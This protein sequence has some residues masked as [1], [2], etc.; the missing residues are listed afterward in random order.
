MRL[1][2][3]RCILKLDIWFISRCIDNKV[4]P[5]FC[6]VKTPG[7][8]PINLKN[9]FQLKIL[10]KEICNHYSKINYINCKLKVIYDSLLDTIG[11]D[12]LSSFLNDVQ[13]KLDNV[14]SIK[15][16]RLKSKLN[17]LIRNKVILH[18]NNSN[19][20]FSNFVFH[21]R[22]KNLSSVVFNKKEIDLLNLG[23]KYSIP[24]KVSVKDLQS[25]SIEL[26]IIIQNLSVPLNQKTSIRNSCFNTINKFKNK[27]N[28]SSSS[29]NLS[30]S[31]CIEEVGGDCQ[32]S[33]LNSNVEYWVWFSFDELIVM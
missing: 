21:P 4:F 9:T 29:I 8:V 24:K 10:K 7:N 3:K 1:A 15:F 22:L 19:T 31:Q 6:K 30:N 13:D 23:L 32:M 2:T 16:N 17:N 14:T 25:L 5:K 26:D 12:N 20:T 27:Y 33:S 28:S 18:N 11:F